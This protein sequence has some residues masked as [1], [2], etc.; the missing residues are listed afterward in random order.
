MFKPIIVSTKV[1]QPGIVVAER[2]FD[3]LYLGLSRSDDLLPQPHYYF[4]W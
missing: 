2:S 1:Q 4:G 3:M